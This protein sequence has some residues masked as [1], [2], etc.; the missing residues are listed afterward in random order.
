MA[1]SVYFEVL[2]GNVFLTKLESKGS[3]FDQCQKSPHAGPPHS[4]ICGTETMPEHPRTSPAP[5]TP[6]T[7]TYTHSNPHQ[8]PP[9]AAPGERCVKRKPFASSHRHTHT[10]TQTKVCNI[11]KSTDWWKFSFLFVLADYYGGQ[12]CVIE[13]LFCLKCLCLYL[14]ILQGQNCPQDVC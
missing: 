13:S 4:Y 9:L 8:L 14:T 6:P 3:P 5:N 1:S 12:Y 2:K 7:H 11:H 10:Y